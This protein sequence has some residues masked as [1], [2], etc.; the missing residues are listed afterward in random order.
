MSENAASESETTV[1]RD[2][3]RPRN[4]ITIRDYERKQ[5]VEF[6][7]ELIDLYEQKELDEE[8][9]L[10]KELVPVF[11]E[12]PET[13]FDTY[14]CGA[15]TWR[16]LAQALEELDEMRASWLSAKIGR[17]AE[18]SVVQMGFTTTVPAMTLET[19]VEPKRPDR[20]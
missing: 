2:I 9:A 4:E 5:L 17:R 13:K 1:E 14:D 7:P 19:G 12:E 20:S 8:A 11:E 16:T 15:D 18:L 6:L 10:F 3:P